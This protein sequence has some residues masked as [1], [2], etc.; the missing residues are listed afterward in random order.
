MR[1]GAIVLPTQPERNLKMVCSEF[2]SLYGGRYLKAEDVSGDFVATITN[3]TVASF[4]KG[5]K[6]VLSLE[7]E[8]QGFVVNTT[9]AVA[10]RAAFGK[11]F[12]GW[13]GKT[14]Q[15]RKERAMF[16]GKTVPALRVYPLRR[17]AP[18]VAPATPNPT[19][20]QTSSAAEPN[21]ELPPLHAYEDDLV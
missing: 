19:V 15:V 17:G 18:P 3:V 4:E 6:A 16:A 10:L 5:P 9:N 21:G 1:G 14:V 12:Q 7:G 2:D 13:I 20:R 8:E 11:D